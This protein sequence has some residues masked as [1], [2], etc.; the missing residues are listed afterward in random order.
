VLLSHRTGC[1][2]SLHASKEV[3]LVISATVWI[4]VLTVTPEDAQMW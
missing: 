2:S 4:S 3:I 1:E